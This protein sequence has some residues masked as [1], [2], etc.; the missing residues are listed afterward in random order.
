MAWIGDDQQVSDNPPEHDPRDVARR[1][2]EAMTAHDV[3]A[4]VA[5]FAQDYR[6]EAPAR[7]GEAI[8]G[9]GKVRENFEA[10]FRDLPDLRAELLGSVADSDAVWMEWRMHGT[11]S[12]GTRM[13]FVGVN[14]FGVR[15]DRF[16]WGR[17]YTE[18]VRDVGGIDGQIQRMTKGVSD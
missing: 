13:E 14:L 2:T 4:A 9:I 6:D 8:S 18:L 5:C 3:E 12:D 15:E 16:S 10:L 7:R 17:I 11:R 1:W